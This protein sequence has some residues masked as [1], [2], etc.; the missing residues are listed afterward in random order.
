MRHRTRVDRTVKEQDQTLS[1]VEDQ[2]TGQL[3]GVPNELAS[4]IAAAFR[5]GWAT[6]YQECAEGGLVTHVEGGR[7]LEETA[8]LERWLFVEAA[9]APRPVDDK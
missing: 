9:F 8:A 6:G 5:A 4:A 3:G 1:R 2:R 7:P